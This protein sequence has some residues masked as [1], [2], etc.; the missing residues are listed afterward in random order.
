M[1]RMN[2][3]DTGVHLPNPNADKANAQ[4]GKSLEALLATKSKRIQEELTKFRVHLPPLPLHKP[5]HSHI[6]PPLQILHNELEGSLQY[7]QERLEYTSSELEKQK[8][9]NEKLENDLVAM[10]KHNKPGGNGVI[11]VDGSGGL[12]PSGMDSQ[13]DL[14]AGLELG[15]KPNVSCLLFFFRFEGLG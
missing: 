14:L 6:I 4:Q 11:G 3:Y 2:G 7:V 8:I 5:T 1:E 12:T 9:L 10:N 13:T 15:K